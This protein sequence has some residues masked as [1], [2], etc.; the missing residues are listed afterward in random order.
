MRPTLHDYV[1]QLDKPQSIDVIIKYMAEAFQ[2]TLKFAKLTNRAPRLG[3]FVA[4][5]ENEN[6]IILSERGE[7]PEHERVEEQNRYQAAQDR[8]IFAGDW[9]LIDVGSVTNGEH[10]V[11]FFRDESVWVQKVTDDFDW[12]VNRIEDL[13]REIEFKEGVV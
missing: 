6:P 10:N 7:I 2:R 4:C 9:E 8:V 13:P 5:D 1:E 11:L 12:E 3:D